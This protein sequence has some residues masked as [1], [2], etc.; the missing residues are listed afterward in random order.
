MAR[1][2]QRFVILLNA[3]RVLSTDEIAELAA[4]SVKDEAN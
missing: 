4:L 3:D 1:I 2:S